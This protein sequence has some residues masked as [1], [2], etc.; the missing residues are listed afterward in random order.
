MVYQTGFKTM[1]VTFAIACL[2]PLGMWVYLTWLNQR[3]E[4]K[5]RESGGESVYAPNEELL[6]LTDWEQGHFRYS[7]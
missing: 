7:K 3:K 4:T 2:A 1:I 6:D 5:L